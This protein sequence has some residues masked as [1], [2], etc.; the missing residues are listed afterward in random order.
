MSDKISYRKL[1]RYKYQ[2]MEEFVILIDIQ[3]AADI[4]LQFLGL[5]AAGQLRIAK[6]YAWDGPSGPTIDTKD[7]M[8]GALVHDALYQLMRLSQLDHT[9]YRDRADRILQELCRQDGMSAF[10]AWYVYHALQLF[11]AKNAEPTDE[12]EVEIITAP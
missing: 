8:R 7:F 6:G 10:R 11:G 3:P 2:L 9:Q 12:P 4:D 1:R 5:S